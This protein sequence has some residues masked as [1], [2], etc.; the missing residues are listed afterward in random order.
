MQR[1]LSGLLFVCVSVQLPAQ[2]PRP[3]DAPLPLSPGQTAHSFRVPAGFRVDLVACE[4]LIREPTGLCWDEYGQLF[5]CELHGYNLEGQY[6]IEELNKTGQL[7]RQVRR[8]QAADR[9]KQAA[10][11]QT[12][13][14]IKRLHDTDGDGQMDRADLWADRL[15]PCLGICPARGGII[16]ACQSQILYLADHDGNGVAEV[17]DVL[18]DGFAKGPLERSI[19]SPQWGPDDWIY[20]GSGSG[21]GT[22]RG[23]HL[24]QPVELARTDFRIKADGSAIEPIV[25]STGTMGFAFTDEGDRFVISTSGPGIF[26]APFEWRHL[27]RN[28]DISVPPLQQPA[29]VDPRCWPTSPPHPWRTR[30]AAD[31]GFSKYYRD[32]YGIA[33]SAPNGY[34]TSACSPLVYR[35]TTLPGLRGQLFACEPAQNL[36]HRAQIVHDGSILQLVRTADEQQ[37]EFFTST[38]PWFH[39]I[40]LAHTPDGRLMIVDFYREIIED[41]SAIPRYLQQEYGLMGGQQ[42]GRLWRLSP[43][44]FPSQSEVMPTAMGSLTA[45]QLAGELI[46]EH[47]WRRETARRLLIERRPPGAAP[48]LHDVLSHAQ[49]PYSIL[50]VMQTLESLQILQTHHIRAALRHSDW[51]VRRQGLRFASSRLNVDRIEHAQDREHGQDLLADVLSLA[52]DNH[53]AVRLQV[54]LALGDSPEQAALVGLVHSARKHGDQP[55]MSLALLTSVAGRAGPY[56]DCL[57]QSPESLSQ[58]IG[59][60]EPLCAAI[61]NRCDSLELNS[62]LRAIFAVADPQIQSSCLQGLAS[63]RKVP[64]ATMIADDVRREIRNRTA[65]EDKRIQESTLTIYRKWQLETPEERESRMV[66]AGADLI[67]VQLSAEEQLAAVRQLAGE[68]EPVAARLLLKAVAESTPIVRQAILEAIIGQ[69]AH[70]PLLLQALEDQIIP[71]SWLSAVQRAAL[72]D[73]KDPEIRSRATRTL[74]ARST[75]SEELISKYHQALTE[76]R[77]VGRG[78]EQYRLKCANCHHAHQVGYQVGPDLGSEFARAEETMIRDVLA[79]S[80]TISVGYVTYTVTTDAGQIISGLLVQELPTSITVRQPEGKDLSIL[81]KDIESIRAITVSM[82][83]DDLHKSL[84]PQDLADILAWIRQPT[85][86]LV[87]F[88]E[89]REFAAALNEGKGSAQVVA[90]DTRYGLLCLRVT[91][92]QR[93]SSRIAG[94]QYPIREHP[95]PGEF[96]Y[97]RFAW[98]GEAAEGI[99]LEL[100]DDGAW[101]PGDRALRRYH[102]GHNSTDWQSTEIDPALPQTWTIV[103]R[104]L[105]RDFGEFTL[106]GIAPTAMSGTAYFDRIELFRDPP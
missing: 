42:H 45:E 43:I 2:I 32:R 21:G 14:T 13:G 92:P 48:I 73:A 81:R 62:S 20:I 57:L 51:S 7:D 18:F 66:R 68:S 24:A 64:A 74:Q 77:D 28:P 44:E 83:P 103:T 95:G 33:E 59:L 60:L 10:E 86:S 27:A 105:W 37:S 76:R 55:W 52:D 85:S 23:A 106:T 61:G 36:I 72:L 19:N 65:S 84:G 46:S 101:P 79:P 50:N 99:M 5:V 53:P 71:A 58:A 82:M 39:A 16:A 90:T 34:F 91:P 40:S 80:E 22:I 26:V 56:L 78:A 104:D 63:A 4:P 8:I 15:P 75:V 69:Q 11:A 38:D 17:R 87:L 25:G 6:D 47:C 102:A 67:N 29:T 97:L 93:Y 3:T 35:D 89:N 49:K 88:D 12:Y 54:A 94:W 9:H 70:Y 98:K 31:P 96:R 41:Y 30:R 1:I 100:A